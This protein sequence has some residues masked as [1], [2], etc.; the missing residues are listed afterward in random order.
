M[1][2]LRHSW[3]CKTCDALLRYQYTKRDWRD[4]L[5]DLAFATLFHRL[6][7]VS[8]IVAIF[9]RE[10]WLLALAALYLPIAVVDFFLSEDRRRGVLGLERGRFVCMRCG[11]DLTGNETGR[12]PECGLYTMVEP[13]R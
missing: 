1:F 8:V 12:C 13:K 5:R 3:R 10:P 11:Y 7:V 2:W 4:L 9:A 6:V